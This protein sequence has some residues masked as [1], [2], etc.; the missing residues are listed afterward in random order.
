MDLQRIY[1]HCDNPPEML[2]YFWLDTFWPNIRDTYSRDKN[3]PIKRRFIRWHREKLWSFSLLQIIFMYNWLFFQR[4]ISFGVFPFGVA[5]RL[6]VSTVALGVHARGPEQTQ[7]EWV[8]YTYIHVILIIRIPSQRRPPRNQ[9]WYGCERK[10]EKKYVFFSY[11]PPVIYV[12]ICLYTYYGYLR[13]KK[14]PSAA[15]RIL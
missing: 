12:H 15:T 5:G 9:K 1:E 10:K 2:M 11:R 14:T 4:G 8:Y 13:E 6:L 7:T 3:T